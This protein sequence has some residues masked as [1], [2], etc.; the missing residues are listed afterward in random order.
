MRNITTAFIKPLLLLLLLAAGGG[1]H[2]QRIALLGEEPALEAMPAETRAAYDWAR[3]VYSADYVSFE[4]VRANAAILNNYAGAWWHHTSSQTI[5][6]SAANPVVAYRIRV[7]IQSGRG[8]LLSGF[9]PRYA[10][11]LG[12]ETNGPNETSANPATTAEWG[13]QKELIPHPIFRN[14]PN[15][16]AT[17][18]P[19]LA[20]AN[21]LSWWTNPAQFSGRWLADTEWNGG[22]VTVGEYTPDRGRVIVVGAGAFQWDYPAQTNGNRPNLELFACNIIN[23]VATIPDPSMSAWWRFDEESGGFAREQ[24]LGF[25]SRVFWRGTPE[26]TDGVHGNALRF[27]GETSYVRQVLAADSLPTTELTVSAWVALKSYPN[28]TAAFL[29]QHQAPNGYFFGIDKYGYW[30]LS[31]GSNGEWFSAFSPSPLPK[32]QWVH[33]AGTFRADGL[34]LLL[35]GN[36]VAFTPVSNRTI[37]NV[38]GQAVEVGRHNQATSQGIFPRDTLN[39]LMDDVRLYKRALGNQEI[40][41]LF[42]Y[43]QPPVVPALGV[44]HARWANDPHRPRFHPIPPS[45]WCNEGYGLIHFRGNWHHF[46]QHNPNG[47]ILEHMHWGHMVSPN[48]FDWREYRTPLW[49]ERGRPDDLGAWSGDAIVRGNGATIVYTSNSGGQTQSVAFSSDD[50]LREWAKHGGNPVTGAFPPGVPPGDV[51]GF[52]DPCIFEANGTTYITVGSGTPSGGFLPLYQTND[53]VN[54]NHR[55]N[56]FGAPSS[57]AGEMWEM[58]NFFEIEPGRWVLFVNRLPNPRPIYWIGRFEDERFIPDFQNPRSLDVGHAYLSPTFGRAPDGRWLAIGI[59]PED[60]FASDQFAAGWSNLFS[61]PREVTLQQGF[62]GQW[63]AAE[64]E[65]LRVQRLFQGSNIVVAPGTSGHLPGVTG[66][67]LD[68]ALRVDPRQ[69]ETFGLIVRRSP[70]GQELTRI[71]YNRIQDLFVVRDRSSNLGSVGKWTTGGAHPI[72]QGEMLDLRVI[73]DR[74]VLTVFANGRTALT[75]RIYPSRADSLG[76]DFYTFEQPAEVLSVTVHRL[77]DANVD[78]EWPSHPTPTELGQEPP[79][80]PEALVIW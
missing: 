75:T 59:V 41:D 55:G 46:Y 22:I 65:G 60:R 19:G 20:S 4:Q 2:A 73:L 1:L 47:N 26:W 30:N 43:A 36:Q 33:I 71:G 78:E 50:L 23:H 49:P 9:A 64:I 27:D 8:L 18:S 24:V 76:L 79:S 5:P 70:D 72:A 7:S 52:R 44:P 3:S 77:R 13:F 63:P 17:T 48:L 15:T 11:N 28:G 32:F 57:L 21:R 10:V 12:F 56:L 45:N 62:L 69:S 35:N 16:F 68:I 37:T 53:M 6:P 51:L 38:V 74:S 34:R 61:I 40:A 31:V 58:P 39:G 14:L 67:Q 54:W 29:N 25:G 80:R 66:N 42:L